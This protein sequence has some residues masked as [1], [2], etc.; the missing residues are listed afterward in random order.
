MMSKREFEQ[1]MM[2][3]AHQKYGI[4]G[5]TYDSNEAFIC[6]QRGDTIEDLAEVYFS[7]Q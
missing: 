7:G 4:E 3:L 2:D 1:A 6:Y 5:I